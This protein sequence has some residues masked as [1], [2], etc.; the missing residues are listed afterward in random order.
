MPDPG[1]AIYTAFLVFNTYLYVT[2]KI[3]GVNNSKSAI[4]MAVLY[5]AAIVVWVVAYVTRKR[6]GMALEAVAKEIPV[7]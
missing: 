6:Q 4:F 7:E 3:Y 5:V 1:A 2:H